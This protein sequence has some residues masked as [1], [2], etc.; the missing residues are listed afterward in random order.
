MVAVVKLFLFAND[1]TVNFGDDFWPSL[2]FVPTRHLKVLH[3]GVRKLTGE[4]LKAFWA[5]FLTL[6]LAIFFVKWVPG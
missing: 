6:S 1:G 3:R 2:L 5:E 4:N